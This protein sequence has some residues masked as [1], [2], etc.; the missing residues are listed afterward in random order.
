LK[1]GPKAIVATALTVTVMDVLIRGADAMV[2]ETVW[3]AGR[4]DASRCSTA[5][6]AT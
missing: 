2:A 4:S 5:W 3:Q 6:P 1:E